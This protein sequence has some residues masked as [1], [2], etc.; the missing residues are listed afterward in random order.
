MRSFKVGDIVPL[1]Q[2]G[3]WNP[4]TPV[5][6]GGSP[7]VIEK[8]HFYKIKVADGFVV[9]LT[10]CGQSENRIKVLLSDP[11]LEFEIPDGFEYL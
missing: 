1:S 7:F 8:A 3:K 11:G 6:F 9:E 5:L 10:I 4:G 2:V